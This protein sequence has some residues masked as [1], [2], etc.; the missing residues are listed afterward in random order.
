MSP[1]LQPPPL[2]LLLLLLQEHRSYCYMV[3]SSWNCG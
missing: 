3:V 2:L 1:P